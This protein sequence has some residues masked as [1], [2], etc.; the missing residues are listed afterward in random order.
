MKTLS[1]ASPYE[2]KPK[3]STETL[4]PAC[5][6]I[7][8]F[9]KRSNV[10]KEV[11]TDPTR[12]STEKKSVD[13]MLLTIKHFVENPDAYTF[14]GEKIT[15]K[16]AIFGDQGPVGTVSSLI[17]ELE[18]FVK[19]FPGEMNK[20]ANQSKTE[21]NSRAK[22][23]Y[24]LESEF[25]KIRS[26]GQNVGE[27]FVR[28]H[29]YP[30]ANQFIPTGPTLLAEG[31]LKITPCHVPLLETELISFD[32]GKEGRYK[33]IKSSADAIEV[34]IPAIS[35]T[36]GERLFK[37]LWSFIGKAKFTV[38]VGSTGLVYL[39][40]EEAERC[41]SNEDGFFLNKGMIRT[42]TTDDAA[43]LVTQVWGDG[44]GS[45][46]NDLIDLFNEHIYAV[47]RTWTIIALKSLKRNPNVALEEY[48]DHTPACEGFV[49]VIKAG[50]EKLTGTGDKREKH[51]LAKD[52][53]GNSTFNPKQ[54]GKKLHEIV[55]EALADTYNNPKWVE[56]YVDNTS[57]MYEHAEMGYLYAGKRLVKLEDL[58]GELKKVRGFLD[59]LRRR[60]Q[61]FIDV[62]LDVYKKVETIS[63]IAGSEQRVKL[64][65]E[66]YDKHKD[67]LESFIG[68]RI[69]TSIAKYEAVGC[70]GPLFVH[71]P[72]TYNY[73][74]PSKGKSF[75][76]PIPSKENYK[77]YIET[78]NALLKETEDF[79]NF[80]Q[81]DHGFSV[82]YFEDL[83]EFIWDDMEGT[84]YDEYYDKYLSNVGSTQSREELV[85]FYYS[86]RNILANITIAVYHLLF[87][88]QK[89]NP[90]NEGLVDFFKEM[91]SSEKSDI[92]K[93]VKGTK[94]SEAEVA[95]LIQKT[96]NNP[97]WV[98]KV[99]ETA[100]PLKGAEFGY[101]FF[102]GKQL[103]SNGVLTKS[104][105]LFKV[106]DTGVSRLAKNAEVRWKIIQSLQQYD[107]DYSYKHR[108]DDKEDMI[109]KVFGEF[110][111]FF[112]P[113]PV[114]G[115]QKPWFTPTDYTYLTLAIE[116]Y[117]EAAKSITKADIIKL[118][119]QV[120]VVTKELLRMIASLTESACSGHSPGNEE[121]MLADDE[122]VFF[123]A[124]ELEH[125]RGSMITHALFDGEGGDKEEAGT[126]PAV[127]L[128]TAFLLT[129]VLKA[130]LTWAFKRA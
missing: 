47:M 61:P 75:E 21:F 96:Y 45:S 2:S 112:K 99:P 84:E 33:E 106:A 115:S 108:V 83:P 97:S 85:D 101:L 120:P 1:I 76:Y 69:P 65:I 78:L 8:D 3:A 71:N 57:S 87:N 72:P 39:K 40:M 19:S 104:Q 36:D 70:Q 34:V 55:S 126:A 44:I 29:I 41:V 6:G 95:A 118:R 12:I 89:L 46:A 43:C 81:N 20:L 105:E 37:L 77:V 98:A 25:N 54:Q 9:L 7:F 119:D 90:A 58:V 11:R 38:P 53:Y 23:C 51:K 5:E 94:E 67:K 103:D 79:D 113:M 52:K 109:Q 63:K 32:W 35:P 26:E 93:I 107:D 86:Y 80:L 59:D 48:Y 92:K 88:A 56:K 74:Y 117:S 14:H 24:K 125:D 127:A 66:L 16:T 50:F 42:C 73:Y 49:D 124:L 102:A 27:E 68:S 128:R 15:I 10:E 122:E 121:R 100:I 82:P 62:R 13:Q 28:K 4:T 130:Y 31:K 123:E 110:T 114:I 17:S 129:H 30:I 116:P 91:F 60:E 64:A 18:K 111:S 22:H